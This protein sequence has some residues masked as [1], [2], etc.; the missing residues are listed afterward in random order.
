MIEA[1]LMVRAKEAVAEAYD[2]LN[3]APVNSRKIAHVKVRAAIGCSLVNFM[4]EEE[5][6]QALGKNRCTVIHH[7]RN[8]LDNIRYWNGYAEIFKTVDDVIRASFKGSTRRS[9]IVSTEAK[10]DFFMKEIESL[11]A[12]LEQLKQTEE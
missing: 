5:A 8:H 11:K 7:R 12:S 1:G 6:G 3:M 2:A 10:I 9:R 4:T